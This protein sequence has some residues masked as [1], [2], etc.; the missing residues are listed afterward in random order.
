MRIAQRLMWIALTSALGSVAHARSFEQHVAADLHGEVQIVNVSGNI[1]VIG[2]DKA[3]VAV[4]ADL[5]TDAT[6]VEIKSD[7]GRTSVRVSPASGGSS[8]G[9]VRL[10]VRVPQLSE[11]DVS[12]VNA[13]LSSRGV[14]GRQELHTVSGDVRADIAAAN[15]EVKT[16]S[17]NVKLQGTGEPDHLRVESVSGDVTLT[18][19]AGDLEATTV[20]GELNVALASARTVHIHTTSGDIT[21][22]VSIGH[23][24][25]IEGETISGEFKVRASAAAGYQYEVSSFSGDIN[26]CFGQEAERTSQ[27]GPGTRLSGKRGAGDGEL[28]LRSLS[29]DI[30]LCDH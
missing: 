25:L 6:R 3:E 5:D 12:A 10:T 29:G 18:K 8:S 28:R 27:H 17:G 22:N 9:A 30:S 24:A 19:G 14:L 21:F 16:V 26:N 4:N 2:W 7:K 13:T 23:G 15:V 20:S 11:V 1:E